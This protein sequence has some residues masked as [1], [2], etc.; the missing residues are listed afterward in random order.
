M[1]TAQA[2]PTQSFDFVCKWFEKASKTAKAQGRTDSALLWQDGLDQLTN[3]ASQRAE[4]VEALQE[5]V[6]DIEKWEAAVRKVINTDPRHG[7]NLD[8][9]RAIL[10]KVGAL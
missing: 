8:K 4:L 9:A 1:K 3:L 10:S 7:M 6:S 2:A 5:L